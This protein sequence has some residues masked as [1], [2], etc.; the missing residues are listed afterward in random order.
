[1][2]RC[3]E[4]QHGFSC[5][6]RNK[7]QH[8]LLLER[9]VVSQQPRK[10]LFCAVSWDRQPDAAPRERGQDF[11]CGRK[12]RGLARDTSAG[13]AGTARGS[14]TGCTTAPPMARPSP[15][16]SQGASLSPPRFP[17]SGSRPTERGAREKPAPAVDQHPE[18]CRRSALQEP[19]LREPTL[20]QAWGGG[21]RIVIR[22]VPCHGC[23][24][25]H[26]AL[27]CVP[28]CSPL[29]PAGGHRQTLPM[30]TPASFL[31][32]QVLILGS[33]DG[34]LVLAA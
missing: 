9:A 26:A 15:A 10:P 14:L 2:P 1:M 7:E 5:L 4:N 18:G 31:F 21:S 25:A 16:L 20:S 30:P 32:F 27:I 8:C 24:L 11:L 28:T 23:V 22:D 13:V 17:C 3:L 6:F 29:S 19:G 34:R 33:V 12:G